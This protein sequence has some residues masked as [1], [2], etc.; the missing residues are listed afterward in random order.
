MNEDIYVY[1]YY[2]YYILCII[3]FFLTKLGW[4]ETEE[5]DVAIKTKN[6]DSVEKK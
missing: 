5:T 2:V 4:K 1:I 6:N 3:S